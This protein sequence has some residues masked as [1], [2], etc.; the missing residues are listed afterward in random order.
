MLGYLIL[1][2]KGSAAKK[3]TRKEQRAQS[4]A[5]FRVLYFLASP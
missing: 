3:D 2:S 1:D 5:L 4:A